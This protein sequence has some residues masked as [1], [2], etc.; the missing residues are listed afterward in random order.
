MPS[1]DE[2]TKAWGDRILA[3]LPGRS[4]A[5]FGAG[6]FIAVDGGT[7][8]FAVPN[9]HY[10]ARCEEVRGEVEAALSAHFGVPVPLRLAVEG[11]ESLVAEVPP[12]PEPYDLEAGAE[13]PA[14]VASSPV[15]RLRQ[16]FPGAEEVSS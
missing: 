13:A 10:L 16:A 1:R 12:D 2:L 14:A 6:R 7:A 8:V 4:K 5:R 11:P 9:E 15:E 3:S